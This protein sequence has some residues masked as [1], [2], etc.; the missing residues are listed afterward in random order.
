LH[1]KPAA[2]SVGSEQLIRQALESRQAYGAQFIVVGPHCPPA[3]Q[4]YRVRVD[5]EQ[6]VSAQGVPAA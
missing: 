2:Q 5:P 1:T 3:V 6:V 4:A